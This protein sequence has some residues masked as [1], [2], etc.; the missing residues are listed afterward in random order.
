MG[1]TD[2]L[3]NFIMYNISLHYDTQSV[4]LMYEYI[5]GWKNHK[6]CAKMKNNKHVH[7]AK[8]REEH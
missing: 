1:Q 6:N 3:Y 7:T 2:W 8:H 4:F 5:I